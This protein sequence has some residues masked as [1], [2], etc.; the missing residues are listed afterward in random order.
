MGNW[1][2]DSIQLLDNTDID[3]P[4]LFETVGEVVSS[5]YLDIG[6][7]EVYQILFV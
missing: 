4:I 5:K 1:Q 3:E 6:K 7:G 2:S